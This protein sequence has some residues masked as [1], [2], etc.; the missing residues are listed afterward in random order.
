MATRVKKWCFTLNNPVVGVP[1][2]DIL[3][4]DVRLF[5]F[6]YGVEVGA[7]GTRHLQ[8]YIEFKLPVRFTVVQQLL[9]AHWEP[10]KGSSAQNF[11]Y[12]TKDKKFE[13][14]G[15]WLS[16]LNIIKNGKLSTKGVSYATLVS[17]L[18]SDNRANAQLS[19]KYIRNKR[20]IDEIVSSI[21]ELRVRHTRYVELLKCSVSE[22]QSECI[23]HLSCQN[24][25]QI[26]W[27]VD[28]VGNQGKTFLAH[29]LYYCYQYDLFDGITSARDLCM[30]ISD[31]PVG[32]VIDVTRSDASHF[33]YQTLEMLKN[34]YVMTGKY[35]GT[36]R[37]FCPVPVI[38]FAN[39]EPDTSKLSL[40]RWCIHR[41]DHEVQTPKY[42]LPPSPRP[43]PSLPT[44]EDSSSI[45]VNV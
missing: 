36:R 40:D 20:N 34:G 13:S 22:W 19:D 18:L 27:Y 16:E 28:S 9:H 21:R 15:I 24:R 23:V 5:R 32:F 3:V 1:Y 11:Q 45:S 38:V 4:R 12:C 10:A 29:L 35:M 14:H 25:R 33:S 31:H 44:S 39:F 7:S 26:C 37:L 43:P 2:Y 30:M 17:D 8:G 42:P 6:V 41:L